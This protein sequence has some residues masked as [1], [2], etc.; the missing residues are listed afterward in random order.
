MRQDADEVRRS[1]KGSGRR[2]DV[3]PVSRMT[4]ITDRE[5]LCGEPGADCFR[6]PGIRV[7]E[8][9]TENGTLIRLESDH[10]PV[11]WVI[12]RF[13]TDLSAVRRVLGDAWERGYG[14]LE[15]RS[16]SA[17]RPMPWYLLAEEE[18]AGSSRYFGAGVRVR[19]SAFCFWELDPRGLTLYL[20]VRNGT[21]GV[22][23]GGRTLPMAEVVMRRLDGMTAMDASS[24]FCR[25]MCDDP[26]LPA[27]PVIGS[28]NWY[29]AYG[30]ITEESVLRDAGWIARLARDCRTVPYM[31]IDDGW[32]AAHEVDGYNGGPWDRGSG[33]FPDM[34]ALA[35][36]MK[37][38]GTRPGLWIRPLFDQRTPYPE[39]WRLPH[40]G[41]LDPSVPEVRREIA[42][43]VRR[44]GDWGYELIKYDFVTFDIFGRWGFEM[45]PSVTEG[46][47]HFHD[48][49]LT[50]AEVVRMLYR[51]IRDAAAGRSM[52]LIGCNAVGHL[53]AG[54]FDI[55]RV[56]D[57]VSGREWERT[58]DMGVNSLA[59]RLGQH[60]TFY[61]V[62]ADCAGLTDRA[63]FGKV[64]QWAELI[65]RTGSALFL[66]VRPG[67]LT[68]EEERELSR[69]L[70]LDESHAE[71][72]AVPCDWM[73][74]TCPELWDDG[75]ET[76]RYNWYDESGAT[77]LA[78][79]PLT[80]R[81]LPGSYA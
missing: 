5:R 80:L 64:R 76:I 19:P 62:D 11:R 33:R 34:A 61:A 17:N 39:E 66:S 56:G 3:P 79:D 52:S 77:F 50:G 41:A 43:I 12:L 18:E 69:I 6:N 54:L 65:A 10:E 31:V 53:G 48:R 78:E 14:N 81:M 13:E 45:R 63:G 2:M 55:N 1:G 71:R 46:S 72:A 68:E 8:E 7:T 73:T 27:G 23:L 42:S 9:A 24:A 26:L 67:L 21:E 59:F 30:D 74:N 38:L 37:A 75:G 25:A 32:Q 44:I 49:S 22:R 4:V 29:Y 20:D 15:W 36:K 57:D 28:N 70:A 51:T 40:T 47:W 58:R 16:V 35:A 60:R